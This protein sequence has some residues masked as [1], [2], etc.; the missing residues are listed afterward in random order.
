MGT[1]VSIDMALD[2]SEQYRLYRKG[3]KSDIKKLKRSGAVCVGDENGEYLGRFVEIYRET[4]QRIG[5]REEYMFD[6]SYFERLLSIRG[7]SWRLVV[8]VRDGE[9]LCGAL[10]S[11]CGGIV[12]YHLSGTDQRFSREA[13]TKMLI[14]DI[15]LWAKEQNVWAFHLGGGLGS[16]EDSLFEFKAGFSDRCQKFAVWRWVRDPGLYVRL[17]ADRREWLAKNEIEAVD[18]GFFPEH[19]APLRPGSGR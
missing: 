10:F 5:A 17:V 7:V 1:T 8:G 2:T 11:L 18:T 9:V 12:Q 6:L 4:M 13:P 15:R 3:H 19:R 14:D 16:K